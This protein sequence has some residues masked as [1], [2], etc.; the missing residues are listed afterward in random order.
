MQAYFE[1]NKGGTIPLTDMT[2]EQQAVVYL[3]GATGIRRIDKDT[4]DEFVRRADLY[5]TY[6]GGIDL[7]DYLTGESVPVTRQVITE[8]MAGHPA[9]WTTAGLITPEAF[10]RMIRVAKAAL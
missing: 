7:R 10:D 4:I 1:T 8:A 2:P 3:T 9:L 5:D 6:I